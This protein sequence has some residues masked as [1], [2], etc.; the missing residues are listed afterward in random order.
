MSLLLSIRGWDASYWQSK[1]RALLPDRKVLLPD[2][3]SD[4]AAVRYIA[5]W[6]HPA[7]SLK[8]FTNVKALFSLGAG[9]DHLLSDPDL[10]D[11]PV[12]RIV[13]PD[14]TARMTEWVVWQALDWLRQGARYRRQQQAGEWIDDR[15]QPS[16]HD[17][18][19]G[20][21]GLGELGMSAAIALRQLGFNVIGWSRSPKTPAAALSGM[22]CLAGADGLTDFLGRTDILVSLLPLTPQTEGVLNASLF[23]RLKQGGRLGGPVLLNAGRGGLQDE[24]A[25]LDALSKGVLAG[26]SLD[27]FRKEP[28]PEGSPFYSHPRVRVTP[29]NA[30]MSHPDAIAGQ[31]V[32][33][34]RR[35]D[36]GGALLHVVDRRTGY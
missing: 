25:I 18:T 30:A 7:G 14:L 4:P 22:P 12:T 36:S 26:A 19:V 33:Q 13:D 35:L 23:A 9:V 29:H 21:M 28:L 16:A 20:I 11:A 24:D 3:V 6:K 1:F 5:T 15:E 17:V 10:P 2:E 8:H 27:V 31:I 34:M 32:D